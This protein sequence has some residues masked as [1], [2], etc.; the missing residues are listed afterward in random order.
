MFSLTIKRYRLSVI[1]YLYKPKYLLPYWLLT[2]SDNDKG[3]RVLNLY[4]VD[5]C[6]FSGALSKTMFFLEQWASESVGESTP[7]YNYIW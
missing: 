5:L 1:L 3:Y 2:V 7:F 4:M 6:M